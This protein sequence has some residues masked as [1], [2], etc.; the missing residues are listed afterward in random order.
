MNVCT[1]R[2]G[3]SSAETLA[4]FHLGQ[5]PV[6]PGAIG[7]GRSDAH[8]WS[9]QTLAVI[10]GFGPRSAVLPNCPAVAV[11]PSMA[12]SDLANADEVRGCVAIVHRGADVPLVLKAR[13]SAQ[14]GAKAVI[15]VNS[16]DKPLVADAHHYPDGRADTGDDITIPVLAVP[17]SAAA[18]LESIGA[19]LS[20]VRGLPRDQR[21]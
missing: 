20:V 18:M 1:I 14:A 5:P 4:R 11:R 21:S 12:Q 15:I 9:G 2:V 6:D 16:D 3:P 19:G 13:R 8:A 17:S 7:L 10:A